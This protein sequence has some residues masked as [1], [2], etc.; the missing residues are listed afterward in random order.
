MK[1]MK[2]T[3][4]ESVTSILP[5]A[6]VMIVSSIILNF[7]WEKQKKYLFLY[8]GTKEQKEQGFLKTVRKEEFQR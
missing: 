5:V 8:N 2:E 7:L 3:F 6:L 1:N 4:K